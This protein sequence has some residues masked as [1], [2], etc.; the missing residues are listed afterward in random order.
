MSEYVYIIYIAKLYCGIC[1]QNNQIYMRFILVVNIYIL[2]SY[3]IV[4]KEKNTNNYE[5]IIWKKYDPR[6]K[7]ERHSRSVSLA[8]MSDKIPAK[9]VRT[10]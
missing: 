2:C 10:D 7:I 9:N 5:H 4:E 1:Y 3:T 6:N 8:S